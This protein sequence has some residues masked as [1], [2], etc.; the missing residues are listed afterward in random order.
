[1]KAST[2]FVTFAA[3]AG[4]ASAQSIS[5]DCTNSLKGILTS[6][7]AACLNPSSLLSFFV[8]TN[9]SVPDT[10]NNWL[11]GLCSTGF[12]SNDTLAAV[13]SN[14]TTGCASDL[15][16]ANAGVPATLTTLVQQ[17]Y[18]T[19]RSIMCLKDNA[20]SKLCVTETLQSLEDIVGK[21]SLTDLDIGTLVGDFTKVVSGAANLACTN[22]VKAAF[23]LASPITQQ[24]PQAVEGIDALCGSN[25]IDGSSPDQDG[26]SQTAVNEAF[27]TKSNDALALTT[28]KMA[29]AVMLFLLS[30]FTLLG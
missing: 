28:S 27:T 6:P 30:V 25:F 23:N 21:L 19:A 9:Q 11:S 13:V 4:L 24:F 12:C 3:A 14:I 17:V 10:I 15:S 1:M 18:P 16:S 5:S 8:G 2:T 29:G 22:C 26:V 7:E 20:S